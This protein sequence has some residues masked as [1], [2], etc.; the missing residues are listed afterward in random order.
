MMQFISRFFTTDHK[1]ID[2]LF[3][4][5]CKC[6]DSGDKTLASHFLAKFE[7]GLLRHIAWEEQL[8]FPRFEQVTGMFESGPTKVMEHEHRQ[9]RSLL[10]EIGYQLNSGSDCK[11]ANDAL[12]ILLES[13]NQKEE[14]ILYPQC[15]RLLNEEQLAELL[16]G[17]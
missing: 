6:L 13:H 11:E 17:I 1:R 8:L 2:L 7:E 15:D 4:H 10:Q 5:Y 12:K 9:I 3:E 16:L 14:G